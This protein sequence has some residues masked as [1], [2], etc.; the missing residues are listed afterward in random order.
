MNLY[1]VLSEELVDRSWDDPPEYYHITEL[2]LA[3]KPSKAKYMAWR[4][5][6]DSFS[7]DIRDMPKMSCKCLAKN[8]VKE[9]S[10]IVSADF[11]YKEFWEKT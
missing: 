1:F 10:R 5:D 8:I 3:D 4:N 7:F 2:I 11:K 6:K 9:S